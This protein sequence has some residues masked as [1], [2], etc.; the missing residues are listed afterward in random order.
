MLESSAWCSAVVSRSWLQARCAAQSG[1]VP[2][3]AR[4][5]QRA[6]LTS[7]EYSRTPR[8]TPLCRPWA[9]CRPRRRVARCRH[10]GG[11]MEVDEALLDARAR[12]LSDLH[13]SGAADPASVSAL[14]E[15]VAGRRWWVTSW[16]EA[17]AY[18]AGLVAQ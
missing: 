14:D 5:A 7:T 13:A 6:A 9:V 12:V 4:T 17:P 18:V 3:P 2:Q 8:M 11:V 1:P 10:N 15:V 16:D